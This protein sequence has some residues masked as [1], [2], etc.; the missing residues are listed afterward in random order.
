M[1]CFLFL[2]L[3]GGFTGRLLAGE[4]S[5]SQSAAPAPA[6]A[7]RRTFS[8]ADLL[9]L[10]T[11]TLQRDYVKDNGELE[12]ILKQPWTALEAPNEPLSLKILELPTVG[13]TPSFIVRFELCTPRESLGTWQNAVEA[14][15]WRKVWVAHTNLRRGDLISGADLVRERC[16]VLNIRE[17]LANFAPGDT[18]LEL[19][20]QVPA[21]APLLARMVKPKTVLH[22]GQMTNALVQDGALSITTRVEVLEDGAPGEIIH[23]RNQTSQRNL[24]GRVLDDQTVLISL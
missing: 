23:V 12:L 24:A 17:A 6:T 7:A 8:E 13:V 18:T 5:T 15:V 19:S 16:D 14:H 20:A 3:G 9:A 4:S 11:A 10:L 2:F 1:F 22:R 21:G